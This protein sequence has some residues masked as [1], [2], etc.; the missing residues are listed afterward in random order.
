MSYIQGFVVPVPEGKK[1]A[2][3]KMAA[4]AA[5]FFKEYGALRIVECWGDDVRDGKV[6]DFKR[7]VN[8]EPG[9]SIVFSWIEWPDR[10]TCQKAE[11]KMP[12]DERMKPPPE[13]M[14]FDGKRM[15]YGGFAPILDTAGE[16]M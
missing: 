7:A 16:L 8:A 4:E 1:E 2:Y 14:P 3:R 9:E 12:S 15:I 10:E 5:P 11:E 13:G 6:T